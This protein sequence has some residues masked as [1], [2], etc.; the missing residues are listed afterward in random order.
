MVAAPEVAVVVGA[1]DRD[2]FLLRAVRSVRAQ[3]VAP[4]R[5]EIVVVTNLTDPRLLAELSELGARVV[6]SH[7]TE[8]GRFQ[9][10][11]VAA[12]R[13]PWVAFLDDDDEF[14]PRRLERFFEVLG[15]RPQLG[16]YRNRVTVIDR[17]GAPVPKEAWRSIEV[18]GA[19]D[20][21]GEVYLSP[22]DRSRALELG[23][24]RTW[25]TFNSSTMIVRRELLDGEVGPAFDRQRLPDTLL[26]LAAVLRP[27]GIFLDPQRLTRFR[28]WGASATGS[29]RWFGHSTRCNLE[30]AEFA[31]RHGAAD[32]AR[33]FSALS[34]HYGRMEKAAALA[35]RMQQRAPR[36]EIAGRS[37][38]YFRYLGRH[39]A[40][41][42]LT[43]DSWA[44]GTYGL[45]YILWPGPVREFARARITRGRAR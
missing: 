40:E 30:L 34:V 13:A 33:Y 36:R 25:A 3:T 20:R 27:V 6:V 4:D 45:A 26:Y 10:D 42:R 12:S 16:F 21:L 35:E 29:V 23:I 32:F 43:I 44:A 8:I 1:W 22:D 11:G 39:P 2:E 14:E 18:D 15:R 19:F 9:R 7:E 38:D 28:F 41:R 5:Y 17:G 31:S 37:G 24:E